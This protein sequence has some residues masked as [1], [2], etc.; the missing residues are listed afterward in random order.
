M[1]QQATKRED[2]R[3]WRTLQS[4]RVA[5]RGDMSLPASPRN[6]CRQEISQSFSEEDTRNPARSNHFVTDS[7]NSPTRL[8]GLKSLKTKTLW[9]I[10]EAGEAQ[11]PGKT[12]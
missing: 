11:K 6:S 7:D 4:C 5:I 2:A 8:L 12:P 9:G 1:Y 3:Q 10:N